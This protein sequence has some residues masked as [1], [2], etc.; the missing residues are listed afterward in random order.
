VR[1]ILLLLMILL[2]VASF[3]Q[4]EATTDDGRQVILDDDGT[5]EYSE[6]AVEAVVQVEAPKQKPTIRISG[7]FD[8]Q[9]EMRKEKF[10][11]KYDKFNKIYRV[12]FK[13]KHNLPGQFINRVLI[14]PAYFESAESESVPKGGYLLYFDGTFRD[15]RFFTGKVMFLVDDEVIE[16][17]SSI[18]PETDVVG[19]G[20]VNETV[21][22]S[23]PEDTLY[24]LINAE[25]VIVRINGKK[26]YTE[27]KLRPGHIGQLIKILDAKDE[28]KNISTK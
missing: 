24:Q 2:P 19:A 13:K 23:L 6:E 17:Q 9:K 27:G 26:G 3:A 16:L 7:R 11:G 21:Y 14:Y 10:E 18:S 8:V 28:I 25:E 20:L 1:Q 12:Q 5:W 4:T 15:W 22:L